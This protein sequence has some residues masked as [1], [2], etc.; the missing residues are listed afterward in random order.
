MVAVRVRPGPAYSARRRADHLAPFVE[1]SAYEAVQVIGCAWPGLDSGNKQSLLDLW[2]RQG[3][4]QRVIES[5]HRISGCARR[6]EYGSPPDHL[7][8]R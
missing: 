7:E 4:V 8:T 5:G 6:R 3:V 1:F 2:L